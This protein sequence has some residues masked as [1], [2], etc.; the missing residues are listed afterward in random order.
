[1]IFKQ[2]FFK[3]FMN[4]PKQYHEKLKTELG[5]KFSGFDIVL[6]ETH[7]KLTERKVIDFVYKGVECLLGF[8]DSGGKLFFTMELESPK[9]E[10]LA[11]RI[12]EESP[13][14]KK[15]EE[16]SKYLSRPHREVTMD[17]E[18]A[19][20]YYSVHCT[21]KQNLCNLNPQKNPK[22]ADCLIGDI[23]NYLMRT[24]IGLATGIL[25]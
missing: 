16:V 4:I 1:M 20:T 9:K 15:I 25:K 22:D 11:K 2:V 17:S 7:S 8:Y 23:W 12:Q 10:G 3:N 19:K 6:R 5:K 14:A 21:A 24:P 13:S 18:K